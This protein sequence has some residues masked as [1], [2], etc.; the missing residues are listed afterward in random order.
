MCF[1]NGECIKNSCFFQGTMA[2]DQP[3][4]TDTHIYGYLSKHSGKLS[5]HRAL[6]L[7]YEQAFTLCLLSRIHFKDLTF[8]RRPQFPVEEKSAGC[9]HCAEDCLWSRL[10]SPDKRKRKKIY[11]CVTDLQIRRHTLRLLW[12]LAGSRHLWINISAAALGS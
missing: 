5:S 9:P 11:V 12:R 7:F 10:I 3:E 1:H 8:T 4:S 6:V 2:D